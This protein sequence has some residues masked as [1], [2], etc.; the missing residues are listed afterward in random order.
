MKKHHYFKARFGLVL[1]D[2]PIYGSAEAGR[3]A[4]LAK[5]NIAGVGIKVVEPKD[6]PEAIAV[7][8][9]PHFFKYAMKDFWFIKHALNRDFGE[10]IE[11]YLLGKLVHRKEVSWVFYKVGE[12][13]D[14][15]APV[16][17]E[18]H[19]WDVDGL[20]NWRDR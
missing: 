9:R 8:T 7:E 1:T 13:F 2:G 15:G 12:P 19:Y 11:S 17:E 3:E 5:D 14:V 10:V 16:I 4:L 20:I 6:Y 18:V